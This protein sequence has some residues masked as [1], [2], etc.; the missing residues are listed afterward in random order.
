MKDL[1]KT[2]PVRH[3][4]EPPLLPPTA[5]LKN[6]HVSVLLPPRGQDCNSKHLALFEMQMALKERC[7]LPLNLTVFEVVTGVHQECK[8]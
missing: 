8:A 6:S 3:R 1:F 2:L 4:V 7:H 5:L